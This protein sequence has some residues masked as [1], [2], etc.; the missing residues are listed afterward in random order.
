MLSKNFLQRESSERIKQRCIELLRV[1]DSKSVKDR[2][3]MLL[4]GINSKGT[5]THFLKR[6]GYNKEQKSMT[7]IV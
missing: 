6:W 5:D 1:L 3:D 7:K 4:D 2:L